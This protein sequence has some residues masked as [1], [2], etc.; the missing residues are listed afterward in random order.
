MLDSLEA[1]KGMAL[2]PL[3]PSAHFTPHR[4]IGGVNADTKD[5]AMKLLQAITNHGKVWEL[6]VWRR[7]AVFKM[8]GSIHSHIPFSESLAP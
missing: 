7:E 5:K 4:I 2:F 8:C 1:G 6:P 3:G